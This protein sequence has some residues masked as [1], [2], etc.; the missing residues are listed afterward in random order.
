MGFSHPRKS[1]PCCLSGR[2]AWVCRRSFNT[3]GSC[4]TRSWRS[5]SEG[6]AAGQFRTLESVSPPRVVMCV[7]AM[8]LFRPVIPFAASSRAI[9]TAGVCGFAGY[10]FPHCTMIEAHRRALLEEIVSIWDGMFD[11]FLGRLPLGSH[12]ESLCYALALLELAESSRMGR[13]ELLIKQSLHFYRRP[14]RRMLLHTE[15]MT[16][17]FILSLIW[18]RHHP[19]LS[20]ALRQYVEGAIVSMADDARRLSVDG[21]ECVFLIITAIAVSGNNKSEDCLE[22]RLAGQ[23]RVMREKT[24]AESSGD[25]FLP[26]WELIIL[27]AFENHT[28]YHSPLREMIEIRLGHAW[29]K[30]ACGLKHPDASAGYPVL[31]L[32]LTRATHGAIPLRLS[33]ADVCNYPSELLFG[34]VIIPRL[35]EGTPSLLP[36]PALVTGGED[37]CC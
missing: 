30:I 13:A 22:A 34:L 3:M 8:V 33:K 37:A 15:R 31:S 14:P 27:H 20:P 35:P 28:R 18:L 10:H 11:P 36:S 32:I 6:R 5:Q 24:D 2:G 9:R 16:I 7:F 23:F 21:L 19:R 25:F 1:R 12:R 26:A 17:G 29:R 4:F